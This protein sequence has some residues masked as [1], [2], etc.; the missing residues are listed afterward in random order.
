MISLLNLCKIA[1]FVDFSAT[2][3]VAHLD[4]SLFSHRKSMIISGYHMTLY[5]RVI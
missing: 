4:K 1:H 2:H 5:L 3:V